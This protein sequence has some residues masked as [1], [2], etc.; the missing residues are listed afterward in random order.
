MQKNTLSLPISDEII[1]KLTHAIKTSLDFEKMTGKQLNL[2][3]IVGEVLTCKRHNL[4]LV[5]D[6]IN[7]GFDA[8]D[9][10]GKRV[11]IKTRRFKGVDSAMTGTLLSKN[12]EPTY[13]Y[14]ILV[15][16]NEQYAFKE[17]YVLSS[18]AIREHF[19]RIN[20]IRV[21]EGKPKR[22]N[23]SIAQFRALAK[24]H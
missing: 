3:G 1:E 10:D 19:D 20:A 13:D 18:N 23:M 17:D 15:L 9:K 11:Q 16:L 8:W 7:E 5:V 6:D 12:Y 4:E 14:V 24:R 2:T 22:K 21:N